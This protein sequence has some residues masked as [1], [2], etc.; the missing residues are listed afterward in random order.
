MAAASAHL[1]GLVKA[2]DMAHGPGLLSSWHH[3]FRDKAMGLLLG[4]FCLGGL[5]NHPQTL[6]LKSLLKLFAGQP[7]VNKVEALLPRFLP[8]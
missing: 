5:G 2:Y 4:T 7:A 8:V 1:L 6:M 3:C